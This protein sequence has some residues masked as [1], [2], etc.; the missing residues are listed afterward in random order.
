MNLRTRNLIL[1]MWAGLGAPFTFVLLGTVMN[2]WAP[3]R[4][5]D[6]PGYA[7]LALC[8]ASG[9]SSLWRVSFMNRAQ[10][11]TLCLIYLPLAIVGFIGLALF[12]SC[13]QG[14]CL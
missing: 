7:V 11:F 5:S 2:K 13:A 14:N 12:V 6:I 10:R 9:V 8:A 4:S 1:F 3:F